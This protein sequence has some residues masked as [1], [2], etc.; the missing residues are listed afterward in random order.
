MKEKT[1]EARR[2]VEKM[3]RIPLTALRREPNADGKHKAFNF[4]HEQFGIGTIR[5]SSVD[6]VL[7][8][9]V[10]DNNLRYCAVWFRDGEYMVTALDAEEVSTMLFPNGEG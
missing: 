4:R 2:P 10:G 3:V 7:D 1:K 9:E 6:R 8:R 5:P